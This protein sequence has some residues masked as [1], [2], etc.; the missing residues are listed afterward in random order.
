MRSR[1]TFRG[2]G[3]EVVRGF[4]TPLTLLTAIPT[5]AASIILVVLTAFFAEKLSLPPFVAIPLMAVSVAPVVGLFAMAG[6]LGNTQAGFF[7]ALG[8][9][10]T[11]AR[12]PG[13][14]VRYALLAAAWG[15]ILA[16][17]V[18][19]ATTFFMGAIMATSGGSQIGAIWMAVAILVFALVAPP[20]CLLVAT[21]ADSA[22]D[23][24]SPASWGWLFSERGDDLVPF[25]A[26]YVGGMLI[27]VLALVPPLALLMPVAMDISPRLGQWAI[28]ALPMLPFAAAPI[29]LGRL[30]GAFVA[31]EFASDDLGHPAGSPPSGRK[32]GASPAPLAGQLLASSRG[33]AAA[34]APAVAA[35]KHVAAAVKQE[36]PV[37]VLTSRNP[38]G[39]PLGVALARAHALG[40]TDPAAA[41]VEIEALRAANGRNPA[42]CG[43]LAR[44]L[45][46]CGREDEARK[47][48]AEAIRLALTGGAGPI[49]FDVFMAFA[50]HAPQLDLDAATFEHLGR[51]L[52]QRQEFDGAAWCFR[53]SASLGGDVK[54]AQKGVLSVADG[55]L[56]A[57][58]AQ[59]AAQIYDGFLRLWPDSAFA[60]FAK[61]GLE[62]ARRRMPAGV[63]A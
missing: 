27:F 7:E 17:A 46:R 55:A 43:E 5:M 41:L 36:S 63:G 18:E 30:A 16:L 38:S 19:H 49:S 33:S 54:A 60:H 23:V 26:S 58:A 29:L 24:F 35:E 52:G 47:V 3:G 57:E 10:E 15:A 50:A 45:L 31:A 62:Q 32:P 20:A 6:R 9:P 4:V 28:V 8:D 25:V 34:A 39:L 1:T 12:V 13:F 53:A 56:K 11:R 37:T 51:I 40:Q 61:D 21:R 44:L 48:A 42:V 59:K 2:E 14:V 22:S